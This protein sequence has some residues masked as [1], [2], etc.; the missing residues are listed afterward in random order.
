VDTE[1][2][3]AR[4]GFQDL[5]DFCHY[6]EIRVDWHS[7]YRKGSDSNCLAENLIKTHFKRIYD[8]SSC[9]RPTNLVMNENH[10][11]SNDR[12][13]YRVNLINMQANKLVKYTS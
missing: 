7:N 6:S 2:F 12:Q 9:W 1:K 5:F 10:A 4:C 13:K 11:M 3:H 8:V